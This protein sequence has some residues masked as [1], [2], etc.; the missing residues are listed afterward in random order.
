MSKTKIEWAEMVWN[1]TTGCS[2]ISEGC[3]HCYAERM[4]KRL[5]GRCGYPAVPNQFE[6]TMHH[7]KL[8]EPLHWKKPARIF[9]DSMGDLFHKDVP[10]TFI[11]RVFASMAIARWHT[12]IILTKR[13]DRMCAWLSNENLPEYIAEAQ[14]YICGQYGWCADTDF[15]W[16]LPNVWMISSVEDQKTADERI[17]WILKTP[18][19]MRGISVEPMLGKI[20]LLKAT[21]FNNPYPNKHDLPP[22]GIGLD[23]VI[24]GCESGPGARPMELDWARNLRDQCQEAGVPFFFKQAMINGKPVKMPELDGKVWDQYPEGK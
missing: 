16:P 22:N 17:P 20:D 18:A 2:R 8:E 19:A 24:C 21:W 4:A 1:P 14:E 15:N 10:I 13:P 6:V 7:E 23:W 11:I 12:F 9:V 5:A 3:R